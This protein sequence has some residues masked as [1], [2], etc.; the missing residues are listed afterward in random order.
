[1]DDKVGLD[2]RAD[3]YKIRVNVVFKP[4]VGPYMLTSI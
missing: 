4:F 1:M 2:Q 3:S